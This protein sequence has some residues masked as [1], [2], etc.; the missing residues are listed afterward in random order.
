[1]SS[2]SWEK[3]P[4]FT[5]CPRS[6]V[7]ESGFTQPAI[8]FISVDFPLPLGPMMPTRSVFRKMYEKS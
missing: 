1:M 5:V 8:I 6:T 3:Y 4:S 2:F 7:P